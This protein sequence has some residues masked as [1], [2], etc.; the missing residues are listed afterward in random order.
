MKK[1][2]IL[3]PG[4][5]FKWAYNF[6]YWSPINFFKNEIQ[7]SG[8]KI[9][10]FNR[11][12]NEF[13]NADYIFITSRYFT[14]SNII[15][16]KKKLGIK[17]KF[18]LEEK[19]KKISKINP[20]IIWFDLSDS[21]GTTAFEIMPYIKKYAK[22]QLYS[23]I[24]NYKKKFFRNRIYADYYQNEFNLEKNLNSDYEFLQNKFENK[25]ILSWNIGVG[26]YFDS[27]NRNN[28]DKNFCILKGSLFGF[29]KKDFNKSLRMNNQSQREI[30]IFF[31]SNLRL[32][33]KKK[34]IFFQR[35]L[36]SKILNEK[37]G[38]T[39]I[40]K[41][42]NHRTYLKRLANSK[43]SVGS[44]G[45]GEICYR[46]FEA[47]SM[48]A[49]VI[50]PDISYIKTWPN[51]Y[52]NN[53]NCLMYDFDLENLEEKINTVLTNEKLRIDLVKNSQNELQ[54][55]YK[56]KGLDYVIKFLKKITE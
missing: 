3:H 4:S 19:I 20:N 17:V 54:N 52:K 11:I 46:E 15:K 24:T 35:Y 1:I 28:F 9:N 42:I 32:N 7:E 36:V 50:F 55:V 18:E 41:R 30:D 39:A 27:I 26:N 8:Y 10:Y 34:S 12:N 33:S 48:G 5:K 56:Q 40:E 29:K 23:D 37:Y 2:N 22:N 49:C 13:F 53:E 14:D 44:F 21:A 51:I 47:I 16:I 45:W 31:K 38:L 43:V 25:L 6:G